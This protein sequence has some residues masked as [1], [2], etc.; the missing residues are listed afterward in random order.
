MDRYHDVEDKGELE[1][2]VFA[3]FI[4]ESIYSLLLLDILNWKIEI[5]LFSYF[6]GFTMRKKVI[7]IWLFTAVV[8]SYVLITVND[9]PKV[10]ASTLYV[11]G[12][13]PGNFSKIQ[14]AIENGSNGDTIFV[15]SGTYYENIAI[16]KTIRLIGENVDNTI[17]EGNRS[18]DVINIY[19]DWV[20]ILGFSITGGGWTPDDY[21]LVLEGVHN[22]TINNNKITDNGNGIFLRDSNDNTIEGNNISDNIYKGIS[23]VTS[24]GN[25]IKNNKVIDNRYGIS[26]SYSNRNDIVGNNVSNGVVKYGI[27]IYCSAWNYISNNTILNNNKGIEISGCIAYEVGIL[28]ENNTLSNNILSH[29]REN[30]LYLYKCNNNKIIGNYINYNGDGIVLRFSSINQIHTNFILDNKD[31]GVSITHSSWNNLSYN[32]ILQNG[33]SIRMQENRYQEHEFSTNNTIYKNNISMSKFGIL[34]WSTYLNKIIQNTISHHNGNGISL[35]DSSD[36]DILENSI[37][38]NDVGINLRFSSRNSIDDNNISNNQIGIYSIHGEKSDASTFDDNTFIN[39]SIHIE[40][41]SQSDD[42][43]DDTSG[44]LTTD[45]ETPWWFLMAFGFTA[46]LMLIGYLVNHARDKTKN[47]Q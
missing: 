8:F 3:K 33:V 20:D 39:N 44:D 40:I 37:H 14:W 16:N 18:G 1:H 11:G 47:R 19:A 36:I 5:Y 21:P 45:K 28:S 17:I 10:N 13:G 34:I 2:Y 4:F 26:I 7:V 43:K 41:Y 24:D 38:N 15:Y 30:G 6:D 35:Y 31:N 23:L 42:D 46:L 22:C 27:K 29:N 9:T 12:A 32:N 25:V